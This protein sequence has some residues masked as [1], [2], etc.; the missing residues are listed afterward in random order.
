LLPAAV[1]VADN[2][3]VAAPC[4]EAEFD[5][6]LAKAFLNAGGTITFS[7][8]GPATISLVGQKTITAPNNVIIDAQT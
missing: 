8:G 5:A 3:V 7:C 2:A 6:A 4:G 1:V